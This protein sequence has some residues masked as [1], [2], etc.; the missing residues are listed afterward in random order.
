MADFCILCGRPLEDSTCDRC[1][2][3]LEENAMPNNSVYHGEIHGYG[4][5]DTYQTITIKVSKEDMESLLHMR[6]IDITET[7]D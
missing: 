5:Y 4:E 7:K 6:K 3:M 2:C 1:I